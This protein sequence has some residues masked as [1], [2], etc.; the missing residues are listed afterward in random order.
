MSEPLLLRLFPMAERDRGHEALDTAGAGLV[1]RLGVAGYALRRR[2]R[3]GPGQQLGDALEWAAAPGVVLAG[4]LAVLA[5]VLGEWAPWR[6]GGE[7]EPGWLGHVGPFLTTG[8]FVFPVYAAALVAV[9]LGAVRV[10]RLLVV[11]AY[12]ASVAARIG[13]GSTHTVS[14]GG[15]RPHVALVHPPA[16][17]VLLAA[18]ALLCLPALLTPR[19][20]APTWRAPALAVLAAAEASG[21]LVT[22]HSVFGSY[23]E[24]LGFVVNMLAELG[25]AFYD[26]AL[27]ALVLI[28]VL[29]ATRRRRAARGL[30]LLLAPWTLL[31]GLRTGY[32]AVPGAALLAWATGTLLVCALVVLLPDRREPVHAVA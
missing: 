32:E 28:A 24:R 26:Y 15:G 23:N 20:H 14:I 13:G 12:V 16:P 18:L 30:S 25:A 10:T 27:P 17:F 1:E 31:V 9:L 29:A 11:G 4:T 2:L 19:V 3:L 21:L 22:Y 6:S 8:V 5:F 7:Q